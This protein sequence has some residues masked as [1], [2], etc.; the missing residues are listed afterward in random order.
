MIADCSL[1][2][3]V[4]PDVL[5]KGREI[6]NAYREPSYLDDQ[7]RPKELDK[8]IKEL[9]EILWTFSANPRKKNKKIVLSF[10]KNEHQNMAVYI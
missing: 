4:P 3:T 1:L 9:E 2:T 8:D 7:S 6:A 5:G 10:F